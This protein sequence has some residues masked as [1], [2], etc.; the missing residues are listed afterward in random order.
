MDCTL[1]QL[2]LDPSADL[3]ICLRDKFLAAMISMRRIDQFLSLEE[4]ERPLITSSSEMAIQ[5]DGS[6]GWSSESSD[7]TLPGTQQKT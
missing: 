6:F 2:H 1:N 4:I 3:F 7:I 5:I